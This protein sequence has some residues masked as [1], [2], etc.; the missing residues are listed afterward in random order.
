[1]LTLRDRWPSLNAHVVTLPAGK[2]AIIDPCYVINDDV[3]QNELM[4]L[5]YPGGP[6]DPNCQKDHDIL[7]DSEH[8]PMLTW[9][10]R[11]GDGSY[12]VRSKLPGTTPEDRMLGV[13]SGCL[14]IVPLGLVDREMLALKGHALEDWGAVVTLSWPMTFAVGSGNLGEVEGRLAVV[15]DEREDEGRLG[16]WS[17]EDDSEWADDEGFDD[18]E[19]DEDDSDE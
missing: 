6:D 10:T 9:K 3:Y 16:D 19:E 18:Y 2:Y 7:V 5:W 8:G 17:D 15:T 11:H 12:P 14:A 4:D 1:M 13:D